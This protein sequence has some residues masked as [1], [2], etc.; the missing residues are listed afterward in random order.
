MKN[1]LTLIFILFT[2]ISFGQENYNKWSVGLNVGAHDGMA[3]TKAYSRVY[4]F[5]HYKLNGRY[6]FNNRVGIML[7]FSYDLFKF[8]NVDYKTN[9]T[10]TT[11]Y[12]VV[13]AGDLLRFDTWTSRIGLLVYGGAGISNMWQK[14]TPTTQ[15]DNR[16]FGYA[17]DM[18]NF[19]FG[20]RPQFKVNER[21]SLNADLAFIFHHNQTMTFDMQSKSNH[22]AIDGYFMN[23]SVGAS[24]YIG[25]HKTHADW[26]PTLRAGMDNE[27]YDAYE[28]R[29]KTLEDSLANKK[30]V[31]DRDEDGIPDEYD[32]CP[33]DKGLYSNDGCPDTDGDGV[34]DV[35]DKCPEEAGVKENAGCPEIEQEIHDVMVKAIDEV[36]FENA[37]SVLRPESHEVLD[38]VVEVLKENL[39]YNLNVDGY[40]DAVGGVKPNL[41]LS[42]ERAESVKKY[43]VSKGVSANRIHTF[44]HGE[45]LP[46]ASNETSEGRALNRRVEFKIVFD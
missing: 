29:I 25:K 38:A 43:I 3:P 46:I 33:D 23:V 7:D 31:S 6:M 2:L 36:E 28:S 1:T 5:N 40:A 34:Y 39:E 10:K 37:K 41:K 45:E 9:Y 15:K 12:G 35:K 21:I 17:D 26:T 20:A 27:K 22:G 14:K 24:F 8:K 18:L 44:G 11:I 4:Q 16:L 32:V 19:A 13:N 30:E 42:K